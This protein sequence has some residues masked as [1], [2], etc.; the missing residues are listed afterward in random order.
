MRW[1]YGRLSRLFDLW[2][3]DHSGTLDFS[4]FALGMRKFHEAKDVETTVEESMEAMISFDT[5][6]DQ[7]LDRKEFAEFLIQFAATANVSLNELIDFMVVSSS[8]KDNSEAETAYISSVK[9]RSTKQMKERVME[10]NPLSFGN[11]WRG[12]GK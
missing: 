7:K 9:E 6:R 3:L 8:L 10:N 4:E 1:R 5:D 11:L 12:L 2:D